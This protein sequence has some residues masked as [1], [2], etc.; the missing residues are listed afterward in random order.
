MTH[1]THRGPSDTPGRMESHCV[2]S[3][4]PHPYCTL[5]ELDSWDL[6]QT[7]RELS[8]D[9]EDQPFACR[10]AEVFRL[11]LQF[12]CAHGA[13]K[14]EFTTFSNSG[15]PSTNAAHGGRAISNH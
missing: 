10:D 11:H 7:L 8:R 1:P 4:G 3:I 9:R 6:Q 13:P 5:Q 14:G 15:P 2:H 12:T